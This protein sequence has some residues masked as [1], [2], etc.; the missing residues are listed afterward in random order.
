MNRILYTVRLRV[1]HRLYTTP[2][3]LPPEAVQR[4]AKDYEAIFT[5][6]TEAESYVRT[7]Y[8]IYLNPFANTK[9]LSLKNGWLSR[10]YLAPDWVSEENYLVHDGRGLSVTDLCMRIAAEGYEP[11][12]MAEY[13]SLKDWREWWEEATCH[14]PLSKKQA[15]KQQVGL[16]TSATNP[17]DTLHIHLA[18]GQDDEVWIDFD[19]SHTIPFE[20]L[21]ELA[22]SFGLPGP[23]VFMGVS[24][25]TWWE[26]IQAKTTDVQKAVIGKLV[27]PYPY[28]IIEVG[29]E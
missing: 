26:S 9:E 29:L 16:V 15:L 14:L 7:H 11:P 18:R 20:R 24:L 22:D 5:T 19:G 4:P 1:G 6:K 21:I 23:E 8:P 12:E 28:E 2:Y 17:F 3:Q 10:R 25:Y 27:D 13:C